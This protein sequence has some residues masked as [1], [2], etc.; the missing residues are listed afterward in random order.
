[1]VSSS[2]MALLAIGDLQSFISASTSETGAP[3]T[4]HVTDWEYSVPGGQLQLAPEF[5]EHG[6]TAE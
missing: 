2:I 4:A 3:I 1:M 6:K 5:V